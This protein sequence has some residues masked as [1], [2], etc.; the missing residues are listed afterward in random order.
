MK[1]TITPKT[2]PDPLAK[3]LYSGVNEA[4]ALREQDAMMGA[5]NEATVNAVA[6]SPHPEAGKFKA[7][8]AAENER[9]RAVL[10]GRYY[11]TVVFQSN[12]QKAAF[13]KGAG[14]SETNEA[15]IDGRVVAQKLGVAIPVEVV[16][17]NG[18]KCEPATINFEPIEPLPVTVQQKKR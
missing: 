12:E 5:F 15:I 10:Q 3:L 4:D 13:V 7:K 1:P 14:W 8:Q 18:E 6:A 11:V 17:F 16:K 2:L 9:R